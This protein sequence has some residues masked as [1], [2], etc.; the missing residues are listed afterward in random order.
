MCSSLYDHVSMITLNELISRLRLVTV[1][2]RSAKDNMSFEEVEVMARFY[3]DWQN[4]NAVID[5]A[6]EMAQCNPDGL[7]GVMAELAIEV[8]AAL[9]VLPNIAGIDFEKIGTE[10][11]GH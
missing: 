1:I 11:G 5:A 9:S 7:K 10:Y 8:Q 4:T 6:E 2:C 3:H